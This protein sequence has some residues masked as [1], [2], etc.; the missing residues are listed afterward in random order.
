MAFVTEKTLFIHVQKTGGMS[1]REILYRCTPTGHESGDAQ[2][3]RHLGLPELRARHP[4]IDSGRIV[5]G[6]VRHPVDWIVSR[7]SFAC[8]SGF[9]IHVQHR[10]TAAQVWMACCWSYR[11]EEFV[12]RYIERFAGIATQ[13][14]FQKLGLWS[15]RPADRIGKTETLADDL[16]KILDDAGERWSRPNTAPHRNADEPGLR[17]QVTAGVRQRIMDAERRL[18]DRFGY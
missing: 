13:T 17:P 14:M 5:F 16:A 15:D 1:V 10:D 2:G 3:E 11:F 18:C 6:F 7:W 9:P 8:A 4:G 12:D